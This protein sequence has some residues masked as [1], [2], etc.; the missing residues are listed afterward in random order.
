MLIKP[1]VA[2]EQ[3]Y[4]VPS[5]DMDLVPQITP[6][7]M[8]EAEQAAFACT[9]YC[10]TT[11][12]YTAWNGTRY[13]M[14]EFL[15]RKMRV[16]IPQS[17]FEVASFSADSRRRFVDAIDLNYQYAMEVSGSEPSGSGLNTIAFVYPT[18]CGTGA[19]GCGNEGS[20]G[21]EMNNYDPPRNNAHYW[22]ATDKDSLYDLISHELGHNF[23]TNKFSRNA[24]M[25]VNTDSAHFY[26]YMLGHATTYDYSYDPGDS[27]AL[28]SREFA[29]QQ[30][31]RT[32]YTYRGISG[33]NWQACGA[34]ETC[35]VGA[36][37]VLAGPLYRARQ[38]YGRGVY[39]RFLSFYKTRLASGQPATT[40]D[41]MDL[42]FEAYSAAANRNMLCLLDTL[43]WPISP[44][45]RARVNT[46]YPQAN[47]HCT[48]L[49]SNGQ[50]LI[51]GDPLYSGI[52]N[53]TLYN[54]ADDEEHFSVRVPA[55]IT[56][57]TIAGRA[58]MFR[59]SN[60]R[61]S[62]FRVFHCSTAGTGTTADVWYWPMNESGSAY[63][64][65]PFATPVR[66]ACALGFFHQRPVNSGPF[67]LGSR[68]DFVT[69]S[70][71]GSY[72]VSIAVEP[73]TPKRWA[74]LNVSRNPTTGVLTFSVANVD[75]SLVDTGAQTVRYWVQGRG[76]VAN[77][78]WSGNRVATW[79]PASN[80]D[81]SGLVM[82]AQVYGAEGPVSS[83]TK[84][85]VYGADDIFGNGYN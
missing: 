61:N 73:Y 78:N 66:G 63:D 33:A 27:P 25:G 72:T 42:M 76:W 20:K 22:E 64:G 36:N 14:Q 80:E 35:G 32:L 51:L 28:S 62:R 17:W 38:L 24:N 21:I 45:A 15:G 11:V 43:Q 74:D 4:I 26:V 6:Y 10:G 68:S 19:A 3:D 75:T 46:A 1:P 60:A 71:A 23:D 8:S 84:S 54:N 56:G 47:P 12:E 52:S 83:R 49:G 29:D 48:T 79:Q 2:I 44:A 30:E 57:R 85:V 59:V 37:R 55:Q 13:L 31:S 65:Y 53:P 16:L 58:S 40:Q 67:W 41:K 50:P 39:K 34:N 69:A 77:A 82:R 81:V 7:Q 9:I 70:N 5:P 18:G